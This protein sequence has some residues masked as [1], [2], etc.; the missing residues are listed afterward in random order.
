M[1]NPPL[2]FLVGYYGHGNAGDEL[3]LRLLHGALSS[4]SVRYLSGP[5]PSGPGAVSRNSLRAAVRAAREAHALVLG[6]G[7]LFQTRTS[8]RSLAAYLMWPTLF[9]IQR[10]PFWVFGVGVD[11]DLPAPA[12]RATAAVLRR[13]R[14]VWVRD[15]ASQA[16]LARHGVASTRMEDAVWAL[17]V[18]EALPA[19][20]AGAR[21]RVLWIPRFPDGSETVR[22]LASLLDGLPDVDHALLGLHP[23]HDDVFLEELRHTRRGPTSLCRA[24]DPEGLF[25][26]VAKADVVVSMRYHGVVLAALAGRPTVA[27]AAHGKVADLAVDLGIPVLRSPGCSAGGLSDAL[28]DAVA[29]SAAVTASRRDAA[30]TALEGLRR[31]L[32]S[33]LSEKL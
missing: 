17:P 31:E 21:R 11:P 29:V 32:S 23:A 9:S 18:P 15:A 13:A 4:A 14:R 28:R 26:A 7:E 8:R 12:L 24:D 22:R 6:G 33:M 25:R 5:R 10:K 27:L 16:A 2:I 20:P 1:A 30:R 19:P 3:I